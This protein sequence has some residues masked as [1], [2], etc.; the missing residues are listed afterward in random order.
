MQY[1]AA[2]YY[3]TASLEYPHQHYPVIH[4]LET[5]Q[6]WDAHLVLNRPCWEKKWPGHHHWITVATELVNFRNTPE[7]CQTYSLIQSHQQYTLGRLFSKVTNFANRLKR[8]F[9]ETIFTNLHWCLLFSLQ[10]IRARDPTLGLTAFEIS[11]SQIFDFD[12]LFQYRISDFK[13]DFWYHNK[14]FYFWSDFRG[15]HFIYRNLPAWPPFYTSVYTNLAWP[16]RY[17]RVGS[18]S[19][20]L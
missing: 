1:T 7:K 6:H 10:M 18:L 12:F 5:V 4:I 2:D 3:T 16:D 14:I 11:K 13:K 19:L 15:R 9:E 8:K 20:P 17:F